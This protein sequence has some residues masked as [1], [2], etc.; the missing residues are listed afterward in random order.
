MMCLLM[1]RGFKIQG[2]GFGSGP[3][4]PRNEQTITNRLRPNKLP[5]C[6]R[7]NITVI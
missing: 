3:C 4:Q 7:C 6:A 5:P 2:G 1:N